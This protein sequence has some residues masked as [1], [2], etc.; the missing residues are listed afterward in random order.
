MLRPTDPALHFLCRRA[1][2][3][4]Q[5]FGAPAHSRNCLWNAALGA[6]RDECGVFTALFGTP[7]SP[8]RDR[9]T[10]A[11]KGPERSL[12]QTRTSLSAA[13]YRMADCTYGPDE[14]HSAPP[15]SPGK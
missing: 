14:P 1:P 2:R 10:A 8:V 4:V 3:K 9:L 11:L 5:V 7:L 15:R 6:S 13:G 12:W